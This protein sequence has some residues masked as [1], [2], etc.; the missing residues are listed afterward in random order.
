MDIEKFKDLEKAIKSENVPANTGENILP[1]YYRV[2]IAERSC[3][4]GKI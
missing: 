2:L 3:R 1:I 4:C